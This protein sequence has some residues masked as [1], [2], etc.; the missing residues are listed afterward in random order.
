MTSDENPTRVSHFPP[1]ADGLDPVEAPIREVTVLEDRAQI[2]RAGRVALRPGRNRLLIREVAPVLQDVSL[3]GAVDGGGARVIDLCARRAMRIRAVDK[4]A[5]ARELE[6]ELERLREQHEELAEERLRAEQRHRALGE[7]LAK[8]TLEIPEDA[9]WGMVNQQAWHDTFEALYKRS[10]ALVDTILE[11]YHAQLELAERAELLARERRALDRW[12]HSFVAWI[13]VDVEAAAA[14]EAELCVEYVVPNALWRPLH[15]ARLGDDGRVRFLSS[16]ALWQNTGEDWRDVE[17]V[18]STARASLGTEPPLLSD[19]LLQAQRKSERVVV[20]QREVAVQRASVEGGASVRPPSTVELP[21]VDDGGD[22][23]NLRARSEPS[24]VLSDGRLN[25]IPLFELEAAADRQLV[26][27]PELEPRVFLKATLRNEA[28]HPILAGPVEL[29]RE[30]GVV[31]WTKV[32]FVAPG[33]RF[34][35]SFGHDDG[36]RV[37]RTTRSKSETDPVDTWTHHDTAVTVFLSNLEGASKQVELVE[38]IPVAEIEHIRVKLLPEKCQPAPPAPD[39]DG[40]CRYRFELPGNSQHTLQL[41]FRLSTA[42]GVE[43]L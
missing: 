8:G 31:G 42:P 24:S 4:P 27:L 22:I 2:R 1:I 7:I 18:F 16:A 26:C 25:V 5:R 36:L 37:Y 33:E 6:Q 23:Q 39:P 28:R 13:E 19:D 32:L 14:T 15:S 40:F 11:R 10:R 35:L 3:R 30:N 21:G 17:L 43:G 29:I 38:R 12:D 20:E 34:E 9:A 41:R